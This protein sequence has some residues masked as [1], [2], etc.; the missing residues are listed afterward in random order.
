MIAKD[1]KD[2]GWK[3]IKGRDCFRLYFIRSFY[4]NEH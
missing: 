1:R 3:G 2:S 4:N